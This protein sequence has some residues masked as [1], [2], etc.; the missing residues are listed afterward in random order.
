MPDEKTTPSQLPTK[1]NFQLPEQEKEK[2]EMPESS[3]EKL[4]EKNNSPSVTGNIQL[5]SEKSS[6]EGN[7]NWYYSK[8]LSKIDDFSTEHETYIF[9]R[10]AIRSQ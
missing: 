9:Y 10:W 5:P 8:I 6:S 2:I 1:E 7:F 4:A 3:D